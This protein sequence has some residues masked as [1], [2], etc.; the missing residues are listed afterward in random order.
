MHEADD[1]VAAEHQ[2]APPFD[3]ALLGGAQDVAVEIEPAGAHF[4]R[5]G[6]RIGGEAHHVA[7]ARIDDVR[8]AV[9]AA[10]RG[11]G[12][13]VGRLAVDGHQHLGFTMS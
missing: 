4:A 12:V 2:P 8:D 10:E 3:A 5:E 9:L 6:M 11:V 1:D 13:E 7:V